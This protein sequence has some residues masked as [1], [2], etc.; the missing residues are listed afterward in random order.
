MSYFAKSVTSIQDF[1]YETIMN[2]FR[3]SSINKSVLHCLD[4]DCSY[5]MFV[6][7]ILLLIDEK[8]K[9]SMVLSTEESNN[10]VKYYTNSNII[11]IIN[12][13]SNKRKNTLIKFDLILTNNATIIPNLDINTIINHVSSILEN[14]EL[15]A[16]TSMQK[17]YLTIINSEI[18][19]DYE[20]NYYCSKY[21]D[22]KIL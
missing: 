4:Q 12:V 1:N 18:A 20:T 15:N 5:V 14:L 9:L 2:K 11:I 6:K 3:Q 22:D 8:L 13:S 7:N 17:L 19:I 21:S 10:Q 16:I